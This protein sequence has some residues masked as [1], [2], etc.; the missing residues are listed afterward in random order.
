MGTKKDLIQLLRRAAMSE[1]LSDW[2][3]RDLAQWLADEIGK[4]APSKENLR[5]FLYNEITRWKNARG[6]G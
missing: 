4:R 1:V 6:K 3:V 2:D 5:S